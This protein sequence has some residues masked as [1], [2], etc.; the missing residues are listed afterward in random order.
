MNVFLC[1]LSGEESDPDTFI[2]NDDPLGEYPEGWSRVTI[3]R[4]VVNPRFHDIRMVKGALVQA[5]LSQVPEEAQAQMAPLVAMQI[6]AQ[7]AALVELT[8][9]FIIVRET[10]HVGD[11]ANNRVL[12]TEY[13]NLREALGLTRVDED[14]TNEPEEEDE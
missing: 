2:D 14:D 3:E 6:D 7:F 11:Y 1:A 12:A 10:V 4:R 5:A 13:S 9:E 8:P